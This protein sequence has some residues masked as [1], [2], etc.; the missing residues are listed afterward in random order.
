MAE[1]DDAEAAMTARANAEEKRIICKDVIWVSKKTSCFYMLNNVLYGSA[2]FE[3]ILS[4]MPADCHAR[5]VGDLLWND[6]N[7]TFILWSQV[8]T[9]SP[10]I[11]TS[12]LNSS[13]SNEMWK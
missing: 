2:A 4:A 12:M 13:R 9:F 10:K 11:I 6:Q 1:T 7:L 8:V 5:S 3:Q